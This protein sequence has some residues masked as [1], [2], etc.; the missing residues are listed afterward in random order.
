[1]E[2]R[3]REGESAKGESMEEERARERGGRSIQ[4]SIDGTR[5]IADR[6]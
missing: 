2:Q 1:M 5:T 6:R 4:K 3:F